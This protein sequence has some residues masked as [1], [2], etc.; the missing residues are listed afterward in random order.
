[1]YAKVNKDKI[2]KELL[3]HAK[4]QRRKEIILPGTDKSSPPCQ[5]GVSE[6]RGGYTLDYQP[7]QTT[8]CPLL[9]KEGSFWSYIKYNNLINKTAFA[10]DT[11][12][13]NS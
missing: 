13:F 4:S 12:I 11:V 8:P 1:M 6:G 2:K 3:F 7:N 9:A 10:T 5:G